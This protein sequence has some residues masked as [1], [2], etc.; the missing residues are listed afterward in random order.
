MKLVPVSELFEIERGSDLDLNALEEVAR[1]GVPYVSRTACN[2]GVSTRVLPVQGVELQPA[3]VLT[4]ALT[5]NAMAS[6]IQAEPFYTGQNVAVLHPRVA[7]SRSVRMY[8]AACL[9]ANQYRFN[10]G[11]NAN[12]SLSSLLVPALSEVPGWVG[13]A[14]T[15][16]PGSLWH[17]L[18]TSQV[19]LAAPSTELM[20]TSA[21]L[22]FTLDQ[23]FEVKKGKRLTKD[24]MTPGS[25]LYIGATEYNNGVTG[26]I[27][28][29]A[30][31]SGG[32][33]TVSYNGSVAEAFYQ[34]EPFWASDDVNVLYP[35]FEMSTEVAMFIVTLIRLEK[36]RYNYGRKWKLEVMKAAT[37]RV[38][39]NPDG[40]VD[41]VAIEDFI[42]RLPSFPLLE[43]AA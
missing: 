42:R 39:A 22:P 5:A 4:V 12:R 10:Y 16:K 36:Y 15:E 14:S 43:L 23:L 35:R 28:Q 3:G 26:R 34:P 31:H 13:E 24:E 18:K 2:N 21:W 33:L 38:P 27:S 29:E 8:Y 7:I 40:T 37:I 9:R 17:D 25:T 6:F 30:L 32:Q 19:Q 1:G 20:P 41:L 11:R